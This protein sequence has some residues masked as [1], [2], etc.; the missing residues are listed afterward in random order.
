[1]SI[2]S[3]QCLITYGASGTSIT[4]TM[5][6]EHKLGGVDECYTLVQRDLKYTLIHV[7]KR[8]VRSTITSFLCRLNE[9]CGIKSACVFGYDAVSIGD[10]I[11]SHPGIRMIIEHLKKGSSELQIWT[12][13][14]DI[15]QHKHG[16]LFNHLPG[17][18]TTEMTRA[19]LLTHVKELDE[20]INE[21]KYRIVELESTAIQMQE[22]R[23]ENRQLKSTLKGMKREGGAGDLQAENMQL[24]RKLGTLERMF[25]RSGRSSELASVPSSS[26]DT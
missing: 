24:R 23:R 14:G 18:S 11:D 17:L 2:Q 6:T 20:I 15:R 3:N 26:H 13:S 22:L 1:M 12:S 4:H 19:Q 9:I 16:L 25:I 21:S 10:E 5:C 8:F 7:R